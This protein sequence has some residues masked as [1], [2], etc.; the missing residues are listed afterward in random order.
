MLRFL[1]YIFNRHL[2][3][4]FLQLHRQTRHL[5][6]KPQHASAEQS[7]GV[8]SRG[9]GEQPLAATNKTIKWHKKGKTTRGYFKW[10]IFCFYDRW[11]DAIVEYGNYL[12]IWIR[13]HGFCCS[14]ARVLVLLI[15]NHFPVWQT[16]SG[17]AQCHESV[18][19]HKFPDN[20]FRKQRDGFDCIPKCQT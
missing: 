13:A 10:C 11:L 17:S 19:F 14:G 6:C 9:R 1:I 15:I 3:F 8:I 2:S 5:S 20:F 4:L 16:V 7:I 18:A 12:H